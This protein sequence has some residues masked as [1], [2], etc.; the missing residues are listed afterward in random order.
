MQLDVRLDGFDA[1][2]G[3]LSPDDSGAVRFTYSEDDLHRSDALSLALPL[4]DEAFGDF[5][6]RAYFDNLLQERVTARAD[7]IAKYRLSTDDIVGIL[8]HLGK[9]CT[10]AV[11]VLP[12]GAPATKVPGDIDQDY[13]AYTDRQLEELVMALYPSAAAAARYAR[14]NANKA[15]LQVPLTDWRNKSRFLMDFAF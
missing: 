9:D 15:E 3:S 2:V 11:S 10:G 12:E 14:P 13:V 7:I 4:N 1:P 8:Y 6:T 5:A